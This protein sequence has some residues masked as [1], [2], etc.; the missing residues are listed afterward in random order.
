MDRL[1]KLAFGLALVC[2]CAMTQ[3]AA[4]QSGAARKKPEQK[5]TEQE[6]K[7]NDNAQTDEQKTYH[8]PEVTKRARI[9]AKPNPDYPR[10]AR[11][12]NVAGEVVLRIILLSSGEVSDEV[13]VIRGLPE[14]VTEAA[15]KAARKIKFTPAE[16]DG[17]PVS[18]YVTVVYNFNLY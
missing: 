3:T 2:V 4:A 6:T 7:Q 12:S 15:L 13:T 16:K 8:G 17:R 18:Q 14:G 5:S 11:A 1:F 9:L 10:R